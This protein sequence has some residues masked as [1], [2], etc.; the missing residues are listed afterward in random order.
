MMKEMTII[1]FF[2]TQVLGWEIPNSNYKTINK[3]NNG[4]FTII[5][6]DSVILSIGY[7]AQE[8]IFEVSITSLYTKPIAID[9][10]NFI[11]NVILTLPDSNIVAKATNHPWYFGNLHGELNLVI[12]N[13]NEVSKFRIHVQKSEFTG[14]VP[15]HYFFQTGFLTGENVKMLNESDRISVSTWSSIINHE[16]IIKNY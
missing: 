12:L 8:S 2:I 7:F 14:I 16:I 4:N 11:A 15:E 6:S 10:T 13:N 3:D 1:L 9:T 5:Y